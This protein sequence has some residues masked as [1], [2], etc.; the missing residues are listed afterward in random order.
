MLYTLLTRKLFKTPNIIL[1]TSTKKYSSIPKKMSQQPSLINII[2]ESSLNSNHKE[3]LLNLEKENISHKKDKQVALLEKD[4]EVAV[5][6]KENIG[7]KYRLEKAN[8]DL[9]RL[10]GI[11]SVRGMLEWIESSVKPLVG[12]NSSRKDIFTFIGHE[13]MGLHYDE[14][15]KFGELIKKAYKNYSQEIHDGKRSAVE[16]SFTK[17]RIIINQSALVDYEQ[18]LAIKNLADHFNYPCELKLASKTNSYES[19]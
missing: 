10:Q 4:I 13:K 7:Y 2:L 5:L 9:L 18:C 19:L 1:L 8:M 14:A 6:E 15:V 11:L 16:V 17:D 12:S 3:L